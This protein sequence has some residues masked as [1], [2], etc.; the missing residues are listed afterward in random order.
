M[1]RSV[2]PTTGTAAGL[3]SAASSTA[4]GEWLRSRAA[5]AKRARLPRPRRELGVRPRVT[6][7]LPSPGFLLSRRWFEK[8]RW[9]TLYE[10]A[11]VHPSEH[12]NT[13][14]GRVALQSLRRVARDRRSIGRTAFYFGDNLV[15]ILA[16]EKGRSNA[17]GVNALC[18]R[19]AAYQGACNLRWR[20]RYV[21]SADNIAD[22]GSWRFDPHK[23]RFPASMGGK[24]AFFEDAPSGPPTA[25]SGAPG[26]W[27]PGNQAARRVTA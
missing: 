15:T 24:K 2:L 11:W 22:E 25:A 7:E 1:P 9:T 8:R 27:V 6:V 13:K 21:A 4:Y 26:I 12:I 18:R 14:E 23:A 10:K 5:A 17:L 20:L 16:F 19:A 3:S